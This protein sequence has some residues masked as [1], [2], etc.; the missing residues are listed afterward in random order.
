MTLAC[1]VSRLERKEIFRDDRI[2]R[3]QLAV[4]QAFL[5]F[6]RMF[7]EIPTTDQLILTSHT[8]LS[9]IQIYNFTLKS[10]PS[11]IVYLVNKKYR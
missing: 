6:Y 10:F 2:I 5:S 1:S 3:I 8:F 7:S 9:E 4:E 11:L